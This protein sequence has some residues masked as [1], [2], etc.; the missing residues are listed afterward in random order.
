[1]AIAIV[2][3]AIAAASVPVELEVVDVETEEQAKDLRCLGSPSVLVEGIDVEPGASGRRDF[4]SA[5]RLYRCGRGVQGWP[6]E[7]WVRSALLMASAQPA[8]IGPRSPG[9]SSATS[10]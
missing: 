3:R 6:D 9:T 10:P 5:C 4:T 8:S 7:S 2:E 1:M